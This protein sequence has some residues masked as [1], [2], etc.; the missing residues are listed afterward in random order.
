MSD[1]LDLHGKQVHAFASQMANLGFS[2][3]TDELLSMLDSGAW[4][5]FKDGLGTYRF[6][7]G[8]FD[9]FLS[10]WTDITR[11]EA[12][13]VLDLDAKA[14]IYQHMDERRTGEDGYRRTVESVRRANPRR[15]GR[16]IKA[17]GSKGERPALGDRVRKLAVAGK[18]R[19][20]TKRWQVQWT[21]RSALPDAIVDKLTADPELAHEVWKRLQANQMRITRADQKR[22]SEAKDAT[23]RDRR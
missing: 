16:T 7:T 19:K 2:R 11:D 10:Q 9:Y 22:R 4:T 21:D 18:P 5:E 23:R 6:L 15:P 8:E 12:M 13:R 1:F 17:F 14:K 20:D 3:M